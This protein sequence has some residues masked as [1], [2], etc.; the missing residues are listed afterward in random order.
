MSFLFSF[1]QIKV[2]NN[3]CYSEIT[4]TVGFSELQFE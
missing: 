1:S 3:L 2:V 4:G